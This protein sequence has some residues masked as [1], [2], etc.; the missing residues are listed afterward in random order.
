MASEVRSLDPSS[1]FNGTPP[2]LALTLLL[3]DVRWCRGGVWTAEMFIE[4][5]KLGN[6]MWGLAG[7][8]MLENDQESGEHGV[9][10][11]RGMQR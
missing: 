3:A 9:F 4:W 5:R 1:H 8:V 11:G 2:T 7:L 10:W 6:A